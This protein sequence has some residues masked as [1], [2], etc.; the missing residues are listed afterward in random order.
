MFW[1]VDGNYK[2]KRYDGII[3]AI[4]ELTETEQFDVI[5]LAECPVEEI[6]EMILFELKKINKTFIRG[7]IVK[8]KLAVF[9]KIS[10]DTPLKIHHQPRYSYFVYKDTLVAGVHL[11]SRYPN[12]NSHRLYEKAKEIKIELVEL[13]NSYNTADIIITGDFNLDPFESG[14]TEIDGFNA[15]FSTEIAKRRPVKRLFANKY[16]FEHP[17]FFNP[18]WHLHGNFNNRAQGTYYKSDS[19]FRIHFHMLDQVIVSPNFLPPSFDMDYFS[20][21]SEYD[22]IKRIKKKLSKPSGQPDQFAYS[23]H[24]PIK[25]RVKR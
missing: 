17:Y 20:I 7:H 4:K 3:E 10:V 13:A 16:P 21:I 6:R 18:S 23:D 8:S 5:F 9:H 25:F 12:L 15:T 14:M 11:L 22:N 1:N 2:N 19:D 24:F